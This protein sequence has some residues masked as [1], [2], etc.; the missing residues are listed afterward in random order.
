M[1]I[2]DLN[3]VQSLSAESESI[4][5]GFASVNIDVSSSANGQITFTFANAQSYATPLPDGGSIAFGSGASFAFAY[6]P[7][8]Y[9][10]FPNYPKKF[11]K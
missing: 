7:P 4:E 1:L 6:N 11:P 3:Y 2:Y 10:S 5:G 8:S 9:P